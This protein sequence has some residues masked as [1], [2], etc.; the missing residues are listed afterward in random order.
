MDVREIARIL[1]G[2]PPAARTALAANPETPPEAL[3]YLMADR[4]P[5][6]R[7]AV[8]GNP[9]S[10]HQ[11][12]GPLALDD[13]V[14]VRRALAERLAQLLPGLPPA[15]QDRLAQAAWTALAQLA[16]DVVEDIRAT[17]A[18]AVKDL[19]DAPRA[20]M[21]GLAR[22]ASPRVA[23]PVLRLC[24]LLT[25]EDLLGLVAAPPIAATLTAIARR[26]AISET[27]ADA[28]VA[29]GDTFAIT[30]LLGNHTAAI[31][32]STLD[33]LV[34][35]AAEYAAWQEPL[36]RRPDLPPR[37]ALALAD[38]VAETL[39]APLAQRSDLP[40]ETTAR[41]RAAVAQ[42]LA[43]APRPGETAEDAATRVCILMQAGALDAAAMLRASGA[44][45]R[46]FVA[47]GLAA[48]ADVPQSDVDHAV[49]TRCAKTLAGLCRKAGLDDA[50]AEAVVALLAPAPPVAGAAPMA[51]AVGDG[52]LRWRIDALSRAAAQ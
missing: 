27:V 15:Q 45:E 52:E 13:D 30:A 33:A 22:D 34:V 11:T 50:T 28:L 29:S 39:L 1:E 8:A 24:P 48:L 3:Y 38:F 46:H 26:P 51:V 49:V 21:L 43:G 9:A 37:A 16:A 17:V 20:M 12:F 31:R 41:I 10:P 32:E 4:A 14:A 42:R 36:V 40:A 5:E 6:I 7:A 44:G 2:G 18:E 19:P 35:Q 23:D 47:T 25:E